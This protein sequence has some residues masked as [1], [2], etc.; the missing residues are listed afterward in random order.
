MKGTVM[1]EDIRESKYAEF[2][3]TVCRVIMEHQPEAV[4]VSYKCENGDIGCAYFDCA[5]VD[6]LAMAGMMQ[7]DAKWDD[8]YA[9]PRKL[10]EVLESDDDDEA[11][12]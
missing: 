8:I 6:K 5:I 3:E 1:K 4:A 11:V 12:E 7:L 9:N 10:K 2:L